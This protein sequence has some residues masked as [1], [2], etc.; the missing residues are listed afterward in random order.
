MKMRHDAS[1][2]ALDLAEALLAIE[3]REEI[4][5][6]CGSLVE[7]FNS[8]GMNANAMKALA[9]LREAVVSESVTSD[10]VRHVR[11]Y[12]EDLPRQPARAFV[13]PPL[14]S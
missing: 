10:M 9:Y 14:P 4:P 7:H 1:L 6:I 2:V 13:P 3:R 5:E 11:E 12:L 8:E